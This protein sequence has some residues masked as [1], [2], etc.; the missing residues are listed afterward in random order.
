M[1]DITIVDSLIASVGSLI[2]V[3]RMVP[4]V[5]KCI[6]QGHGK[7]LSKTFLWAW[8]IG[9]GLMLTHFIIKSEGI[10]LI[11]NYSFMVCCILVV[12]FYRFFP[13]K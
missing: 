8:L 3:F 1:I 10:G 7:G 2:L 13:R 5:V 12:M 11:I 4:Q 6:N 9:E